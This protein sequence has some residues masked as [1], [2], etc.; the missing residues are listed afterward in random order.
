M[1]SVDVPGAPALARLVAGEQAQFSVA[2]VRYYS[3]RRTRRAC[4]AQGSLWR[5]V[6]T[7]VRNGPVILSLRDELTRLRE[8]QPVT[9][10]VI[11]SFVEARLHRNQCVD[12]GR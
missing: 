11:D 10:N 5:S 1:L 6:G 3:L 7:Q 8:I 12:F 9:L 2:T 4:A